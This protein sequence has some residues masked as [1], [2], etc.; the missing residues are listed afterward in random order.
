MRGFG[1]LALAG[2]AGVAAWTLPAAAQEKLSKCYVGQRVGLPGSGQGT[3]VA[4]RGSGCDVKAD[5]YDNVQTWAA[6]MLTAVAASPVQRAAPVAATPKPGNYQCFGGPAG[7]LKLRFGAGNSY[8][9]EQGSAGTYKVRPSGQ[10]EFVSGP[11][12]GFYA[13][14]L[15]GG[16]VGLTSR[17]EST[18]YNMT[19]DPR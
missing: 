16:R 14:T 3:V 6:W 9:N 5:G 15:D 12:A 4:L 19:C 7:N 1:L 11:W 17:A 10:L 2:A 8:A 13:K 18:F